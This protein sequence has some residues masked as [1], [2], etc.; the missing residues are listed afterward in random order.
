MARFVAQ[1]ALLTI[2]IHAPSKEMGKPKGS[3]KMA[4]GLETPLLLRIRSGSISLGNEL[5]RFGQ[6][7]R[8]PVTLSS[9][10][11]S[12]SGCVA[13]DTSF[14]GFTGK[15]LEAIMIA[16]DESRRLGNNF[17]DILQILLGLIGEGTG[18]AAQVLKS[19]G[20]KL[21]DVRDQV[22]KI[23][24]RGKGCYALG[25]PFTSIATSALVHSFEEACKRGHNHIGPEH[26]LLVLLRQHVVSG[27]LKDLGTDSS[28]IYTQVIHMVGGDDV[29]IVTQGS[30]GNRKMR[31]LEGYRT[32]LTTLVGEGGGST[33][34]DE[35][36]EHTEKDPT[37]AMPSLPVEVHEPSVD[38]TILI[39][40]RVREHYEIRHKLHYSD[41]ALIAAAELSYLYIS[42][43]FLP[44]KAID[45]IDEAGARVCARHAQ[46]FEATRELRR[47][48]KRNRKSVNEAFHRMQSKYG[49]LISSDRE[50][51]EF[52]NR[53]QELMIQIGILHEVNKAEKVV[54][55]VD[56]QDVVS[57]RRCRL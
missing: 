48:F 22:E 18:I 45:L 27:V 57:D 24:P 21:E 51:W 55:E 17:I 53:E 31:T 41:C 14:E 33:T 30:T 2:P 16:R 13:K 25:L 7:F 4:S 54:T 44:Y 20:I 49:G 52:Y 43:G 36:N 19:S 56:V 12:G 23:S 39:L 3:V 32:N 8:S 10:P 29:S 40:K 28:N 26:L 11:G 35:Y 37:L 50:Y 5:V 42:D 34:L 6:D 46:F 38:E 15:A 47:E 9:L 1:S